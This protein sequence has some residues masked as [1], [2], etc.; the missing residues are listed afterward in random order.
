[1][2]KEYGL[3]PSLLTAVDDPYV[4]EPAAFWGGQPVWADILATLPAIS[5]SRGT[6]FFGDADGIMRT[7]QSGYLNGEYDSAQAALDDA[8]SQ[9]ELV[10]GLPIAQ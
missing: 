1:M 6:P 10:T 8:A 3:V 7:V 2:L 5:P 9:I 4:A